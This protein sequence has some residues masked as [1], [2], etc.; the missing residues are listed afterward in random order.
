VLLGVPSRGRT[1]TQ[2]YAST[3]KA[4]TARRVPLRAVWW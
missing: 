1:W 4:K 2:L 3:V